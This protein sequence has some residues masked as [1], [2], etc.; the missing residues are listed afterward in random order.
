MPFRVAICL[1][2]Q[3]HKILVK[4]GQ[5]NAKNDKD[6]LVFVNPVL[7]DNILFLKCLSIIIIKIKGR[8]SFGVNGQ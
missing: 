7:D 4:N 6:L 2:S 8:I 5:K 1:K 3:T